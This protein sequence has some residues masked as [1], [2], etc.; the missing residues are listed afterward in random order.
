MKKIVSAISLIALSSVFS[1]VNAADLEKIEVL[2]NGTISAKTTSD[3]VLAKSEVKGDLKVLKD[4]VVTY[5]IKDKENAKKVTLNLTYELE[6]NKNYTIIWVDWAEANMNF[7]ILDKIAWEYQNSD[8]S[9]TW[10][11]IEK[12]NIIDSKTVEIYYNE[13]LKAEEFLYRFLSD[14]PVKNK[15]WTS[16]NSIDIVLEKPLKEMTPYIIIS[17]SLEDKDWKAVEMKETIYEFETLDNL[18][19][20]FPEEPKVEENLDSAWTASVNTWNIEEIALKAGKTPDTW[21]ATWVLV[22]LTLMIVWAIWVSFRK[23]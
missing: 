19:N 21:A 23:S 15:V 22:L 9:S 18:L 14:L 1:A 17:N 5:A 6:K 3:L 8:K 7:S 10:L 2:D 4:Y 12:I 13:D 20:V 16:E 11:K